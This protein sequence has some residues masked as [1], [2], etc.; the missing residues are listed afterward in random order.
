[1]NHIMRTTNQKRFLLD[2]AFSGT[3]L[4]VLVGIRLM[5]RQTFRF[6]SIRDCA[7]FNENYFGC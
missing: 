3:K 5:A 7:P 1:M 4:E 6:K 2:C